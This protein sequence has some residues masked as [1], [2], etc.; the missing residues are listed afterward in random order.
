MQSERTKRRYLKQR[1]LENWRAVDQA[2]ICGKGAYMVEYVWCVDVGDGVDMRQREANT[3]MPCQLRARA[4][5]GSQSTPNAFEAEQ[6]QCL[7]PSTPHHV[8]HPRSQTEAT[9]L[10]EAAEKFHFRVLIK[11]G[12]KFEGCGLEESTPED[13]H[14]NGTSKVTRSESS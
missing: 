6:R 1:W 11:E 2:E 3:A 5:H 7:Q 13:D 12:Q 4:Q 8:C 14:A 10:A 9:A